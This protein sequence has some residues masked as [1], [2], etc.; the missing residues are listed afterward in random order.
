MIYCIANSKGGTGKTAFSVNLLHHLDVDFVVDV[1][2]T[3]RGISSILSLSEN[4]IPV[5]VPTTK[6]DIIKWADSGANI[7]FDCGGFDSDFTQ[8]AISQADVII[9]PSN[10][11]PTEQFGLANFNEVMRS[12]SDLVG[13][14]L[15]AKV[16]INKVHPSRRDFSLMTEFVGRFDHLEL[17]PIVIPMSASIPKSQF[18][19]EAVKS[20]NVA[21]KFSKL[22]KLMLK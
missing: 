4:S 18:K 8:Y 1:D 16:V 20:G 15:I 2:T 19:G 6:E 7:L 9:T 14:K 22:A 12:V 10:D 5:Y 13:E 11:D 17:L 3:H 21:A